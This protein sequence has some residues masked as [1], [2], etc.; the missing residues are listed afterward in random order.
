MLSGRAPGLSYIEG[1]GAGFVPDVL[2]RD[3]LDE[4]RTVSDDDAYLMS[5]RLAREE[6]VLVGISAGANAL[7]AAE[8]AAEME[9]DESV[10]TILCDSG[11][12]YLS[13]GVYE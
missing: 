1:I 5:R 9:P 4:V 8:V 13:T 3:I 10:V 7:T 2:N 6:G 11:M 12:R